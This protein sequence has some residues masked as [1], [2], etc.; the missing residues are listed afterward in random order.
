[1]IAFWPIAPLL[2]AALPQTLFAVQYAVRPFGAGQWWRDR[3]GRALFNKATALAIVLD[4]L[5]MHVFS[6]G[7][8]QW[9]FAAPEGGF[10]IA[11]TIGYWY[12]FA[13]VVYQYGALVRQRH[14]DREARQT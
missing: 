8:P 14:E 12:V 13:A 11:E 1:M 9:S 10:A 5:T 7:W 6:A 2:L 3:V 4:L